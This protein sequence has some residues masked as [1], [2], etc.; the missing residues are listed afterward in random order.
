MPRKSI[1]KIH[2]KSTSRSPGSNATLFFGGRLSSMTSIVLTPRN[3]R[4]TSGT[5]S[6][7]CSSKGFEILSKLFCSVLPAIIDFCTTSSN[8]SALRYCPVAISRPS[9]CDSGPSQ[10]LLTTLPKRSFLKDVSYESAPFSLN[11]LQVFQGYSD[12]CFLPKC[13]FY[14]TSSIPSH[15]HNRLVS[16]L[17][18][19]RA[20]LKPS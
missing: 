13:G 8:E 5:T 16:T 7:H 17:L 18:S 10:G 2:T 12:D 4:L 11:H 6:P 14:A 9:R 1:E 19:A 20:T 3:R 15:F